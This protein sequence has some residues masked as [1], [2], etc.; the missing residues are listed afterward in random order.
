MASTAGEKQ[1]SVT[2][3][4]HSISRARGSVLIDGQTAPGLHQH[5]P[6]RITT[7]GALKAEDRVQGV[8]TASL[9]TCL[10]NRHVRGDFQRDFCT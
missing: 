10:A 6:R 7:F 4:V 2:D 3:A 9:G 1:V 8:E 5:S